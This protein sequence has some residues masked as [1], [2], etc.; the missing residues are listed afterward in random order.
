MQR[1]GNNL[2]K[3]TKTLTY[4][5]LMSNPILDIAARFWEPERY[6]AFKILYRSFRIVDDLVDDNKSINNRLSSVEI[7]QLSST[8][9]TWIKTMHDQDQKDSIQQHLHN[10]ITKYQIPIWPWESFSKSMLYDLRNDGFNTFHTFLKYAE[11]A[12]IAPAS[13][14]I[15]LCG[16]NGENGQFKIPKFDIRKT[17][18]PAAIFAY[19]VHIIRDFQKDQN[20]NLNYFADNL[21]KENGLNRSILKDIASG[22][23]I[24]QGFRD[25]IKTYY[26][27]AELY[28]RKTRETIDEISIYLK[29]QYHLSIEILYDLYL[30]IF[31]RIDI[32]HGRFTTDELNPSPQEIRERI[33]NT[34]T[35][36]GSLSS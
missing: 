36:F 33:N 11:G 20:N 4:K 22:G 14:F 12:S 19:I 6:E 18:E 7:E 3:L 35:N 34:V 17:A 30:Q 10:I 32:D 16:I 8:V 27:Y 26:K 28:R 24:T 31:E 21:I 25:L 29:P 13:I 1:R 5:Q 23:K 15:H 2:F 9:N